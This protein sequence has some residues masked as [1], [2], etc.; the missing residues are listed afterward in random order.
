MHSI[1]F[2]NRWGFGIF[3]IAFAI[4]YGAGKLFGLSRE[5]PMMVIG[6]PL[7]IAFDLGLRCL[8]AD[9]HWFSPERGGS[10]LFLPVW[11]FGALWFFLGLLYTL[12]PS[13]A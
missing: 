12:V 11:L 1:H 9:G 7:V 10:L 5:G 13:A 6:D 4:A 3:I 8:R 2:F